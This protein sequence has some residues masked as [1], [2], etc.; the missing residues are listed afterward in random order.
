MIEFE[1]PTGTYSNIRIDFG[2]VSGLTYNV[3]RIE[4]R[5]GDRSLLYTNKDVT[6]ALIPKMK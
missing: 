2:D 5:V 6:V 3:D 4:L 1:I